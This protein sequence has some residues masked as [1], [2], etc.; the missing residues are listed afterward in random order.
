MLE[1]KELNVD[2]VIKMVLNSLSNRLICLYKVSSNIIQLI[3][4]IIKLCKVRL[5]I[6]ML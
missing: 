6:L 2:S 4:I 1:S 3:I 5:M